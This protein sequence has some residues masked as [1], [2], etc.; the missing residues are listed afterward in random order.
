MFSSP[1]VISIVF[2]QQFVLTPVGLELIAVIN[3]AFDNPSL[4]SILHALQRAWIKAVTKLLGIVAVSGH[5]AGRKLA[6]VT[7][8]K[9]IKKFV[10]RRTAFR[11]SAGAVWISQTEENFTS[12]AIIAGHDV[13]FGHPGDFRVIRVFC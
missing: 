4:R 8:R 10:N 5:R 12:P 6:W 9:T 3:V 7:P 11:N 2:P 13:D 1:V